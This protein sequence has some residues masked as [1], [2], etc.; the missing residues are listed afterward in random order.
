MFCLLI[1][2]RVLIYCCL[3]LCLVALWVL[4]AGL[5]FC[6]LILGCYLLRSGV[7]VALWLLALVFAID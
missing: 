5:C 4:C 1:G 3:F 2:L 7:G 6:W